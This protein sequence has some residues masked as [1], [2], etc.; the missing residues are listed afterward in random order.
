[1]SED[2]LAHWGLSRQKKKKKN[3]KEYATR[4]DSL[5]LMSGFRPK[6]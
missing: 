5:L 4:N 6:N 1:V 2:L 3:K